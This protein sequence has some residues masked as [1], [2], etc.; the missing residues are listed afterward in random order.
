ME[1]STRGRLTLE[2][3]SPADV[4]I[5]TWWETAEWI[6][7][8]GPEYGQ[9]CYLIQGHEIFP[10]LPIER[11]QATY[12]MDFDKIVVS[13]WLKNVLRTE[14]GTA[15]TL[16]SNGVD[17]TRFRPNS[18]YCSDTGFRVGHIWSDLACKNSAAAVEAIMRAKIILPKLEATIFGWGPR[19]RCLADCAWVEYVQYPHQALIPALYQ[20][21]KVW[22]VSSTSEGFGLPILEAMACG[23]P[24]ISTPAGAAPELLTGDNG[25]IVDF[26]VSAITSALT[27]ILEAS[28]QEWLG[29]SKAA[30]FT[31]ESHDA[32]FA[33]EAFE[34][35]LTQL[36][37]GTSSVP[38]HNQPA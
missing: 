3:F 24:V 30:R 13:Q 7:P 8:L 36:V 22:L 11:V 31:A 15:S 26:D 25:R 28:S 9:K 27:H 14:Y 34:R 38:S 10:G 18:Q 6:A 33:S 1:G 17:I 2:D 4:V 35:H 21:C 12:R 16:I 20:K 37:S 23:V 5:A 19:P 32:N 29:M